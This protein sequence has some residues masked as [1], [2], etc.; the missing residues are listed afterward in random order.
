MQKAQASV[1]AQAI[2]AMGKYT[3]ILRSYGLPRRFIGIIDSKFG[4]QEG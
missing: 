4:C 1:N 2:E 3:V